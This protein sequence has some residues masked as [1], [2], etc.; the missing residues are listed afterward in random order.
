MSKCQAATGAAYQTLAT[1]S[2]AKVYNISQ[3]DWSQNFSDLKTDVL[4]KLG[5]TFVMKDT[6]V[7]K[8]VK[9]EVDGVAIDSSKYSFANNTLTLADSVVVTEQSTVKVSY[10]QE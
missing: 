4:T 1:Q 7:A 5:R 2:N 3:T 9:V 6:M 8:I 10:T